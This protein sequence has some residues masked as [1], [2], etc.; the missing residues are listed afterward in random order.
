MESTL[1]KYE[2]LA[3]LN[4]LHIILVFRMRDTAL[5]CFLQK[6]Y[7]YHV[8]NVKQVNLLSMPGCMFN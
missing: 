1:C 5:F 7:F 3:Q 2:I 8:D 6:A 4:H